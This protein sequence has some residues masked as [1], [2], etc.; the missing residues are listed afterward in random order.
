MKGSLIPLDVLPELLPVCPRGQ[1]HGDGEED[2]EIVTK[3]RFGMYEYEGCV[4]CVNLISVNLP[5]CSL[6]CCDGQM[7]D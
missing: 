3:D 7:H 2:S 1:R 4:V 5:S 6:Q